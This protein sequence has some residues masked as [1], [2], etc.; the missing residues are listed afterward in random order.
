MQQKEVGYIRIWKRIYIDYL[1]VYAD[2]LILKVLS[3]GFRMEQ[4]ERP[5]RV[6]PKKHQ[7]VY[8]PK[9]NIALFLH[10]SAMTVAS[11]P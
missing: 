9:Q 3:D 8:P 6:F 11:R 7:K 1:T 2:I 5:Q 10:S 4:T